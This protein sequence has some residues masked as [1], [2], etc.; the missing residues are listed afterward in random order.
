M[1]RDSGFPRVIPLDFIVGSV[2]KVR[3]FDRRFRPTSGR[4][5]ER[6]ER[7]SLVNRTGNPLPPIDGKSV[8]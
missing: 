5:R 6:W 7:I 4:N 3:E 2:D 1:V 8:V